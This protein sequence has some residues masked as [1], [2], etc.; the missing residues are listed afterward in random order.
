MLSILIVTTINITILEPNV[1]Q[2][3]FG[4]LAAFNLESWRFFVWVVGYFAILF[5][6][7]CKI[8]TFLE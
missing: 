6:K 7:C 3:F 5:H 8:T 2:I 1:F 4:E